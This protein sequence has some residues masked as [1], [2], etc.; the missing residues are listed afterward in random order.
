MKLFA[1]KL[2]A[3]ELV[4]ISNDGNSLVIY[5][6]TDKKNFTIRMGSKTVLH[7][8]AR[9][10]VALKRFAPGDWIRVWGTLREDDYGAVD[11]EVVRNTDL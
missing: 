5:S 8:N 4:S 6:K 11:A 2:Y 3:G 10:V 9:K 7:N 1:P